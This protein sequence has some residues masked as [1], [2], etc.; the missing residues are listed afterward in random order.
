MEEASGLDIY[1]E[2]INPDWKLEGVEIS[3]RPLYEL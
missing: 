3:E 1:P 2:P